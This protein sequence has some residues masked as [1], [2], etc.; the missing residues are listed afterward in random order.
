[1]YV[2][3]TYAHVAPVCA[4]V[5]TVHTVSQQDV[6]VSRGSRSLNT[7]RR[8]HPEG[9]IIGGRTLLSLHTYTLIPAFVFSAHLKD[10]S[11][12]AAVSLGCAQYGRDIV[13]KSV[14]TVQG[15]PLGRSLKTASQGV[16]A[17]CAFAP[18]AVLRRPLSLRCKVDA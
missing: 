2:L 4:Y 7:M 13:S 11:H 16:R 1:M 9:S 10:E 12:A 14:R 3:C 15:P 17:P 8:A 18:L 5:R 6:D